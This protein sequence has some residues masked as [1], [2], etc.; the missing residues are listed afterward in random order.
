[1][2]ACVL[3]HFSHV[4]LFVTLWTVAHQAPLSMGI[5]QKRILEWVAMPTSR[6]SSWPR[7][8]TPVS[9]PNWQAGSLPLGLPRKPLIQCTITQIFTCFCQKR[10]R[11]S[12][13][14]PW[15]SD[16]YLSICQ[17][18]KSMIKNTSNVTVTFWSDCVGFKSPEMH[19]LGA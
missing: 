6:G 16:H 10:Q 7:D 8:Q 18:I 3:S 4:R 12:C 1:M 13:L 11:I 9:L 2:D 5:L 14:W 17:K 15:N 19:I